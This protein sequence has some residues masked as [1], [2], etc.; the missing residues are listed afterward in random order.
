MA[1]PGINVEVVAETDTTGVTL[2]EPL[3]LSGIGKRRTAAGRLVAG[4]AAAADVEAFKGITSHSHKHLARRWDH[5]LTKE[6]AGRQ[7]NRLKAAAKYLK[8]PGMIS[9]GGGLP[10]SEYFPFDELSVKVPTAGGYSEQA[11][12][13]FG[14]VLTAGKH[15]L[16]NEKSLFDIETAFNYGQGTGSAQLLRYL[17]EHTELVHDPPYR[18]W[19]CTMTIGSTSALDMSLRMFLNPGDY[20]L[21]EEYTFSAAVETTRQ[22]GGRLL[23]IPIDSEGLIPSAIDSILTNWDPVA[24]QARKPFLIYTVPTG[25][26]PTGATMSLQRRRDLYTIAQKHDLFILED[27]PYYFLQMQPYTGPDAPPAPLPPSHAAFLRSLVP[28]LLSLDTDG[29]VMRMDSF[30]KVIAPG[31]RLGWITASA[32][33]IERYIRHA[34]LSTQS[35][36]GMSQLVLFKLL[37]EHWGHS[38]YLDWLIHMRVEYTRRR[39]VMLAACDAHLPKDLVSWQ[40]PAAGMF[41]WMK[42]EYKLHPKFKSG[43]KDVLEL[44]E[45]I[46]QAS[47]RKGALVMK[48]SFFYADDEVR[49]DTMFFRATYA[50]APF[51]RIVEAVRRFGEAVREE[52][53]VVVEGKGED[54]NGNGVNGH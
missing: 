22:M 12:H 18:D 53:G 49:H 36:S 51:D 4:V 39:D 20:V 54:G 21:T 33:L 40:A 13:E 15:D 43:E 14:Q 37:D 6:S 26:N 2:P 24:R 19:Q 23:S 9:L 32:Q 48:G 45:D 25:Q 11:V 3:T 34:D 1:P 44:E 10:S 5:R 31:A 29:R 50:A 52:F 8:N 38:G 16:A 41:H 27:E 35:P 28:S 30:S 47:V 42:V 46:F 7:G 17:I